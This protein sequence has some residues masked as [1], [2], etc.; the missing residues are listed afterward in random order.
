[1]VCSYNHVDF[2]VHALLGWTSIIETHFGLWLK[3][4]LRLLFFFM[5]A[6]NGLRLLW[7]VYYIYFTYSFI[8]LSLLRPYDVI[9]IGDTLLL[10]LWP[11]KACYDCV[12]INYDYLSLLLC[13]MV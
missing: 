7:P 6:A 13:F 2:L 4:M 8:L 5:H 3:G 11:R 1:M 9:S 12:L 10:A